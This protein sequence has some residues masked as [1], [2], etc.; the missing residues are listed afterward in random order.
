MAKIK[1]F[2]GLTLIFLLGALA[3]AF[4]TGFYIKEHVEEFLE[5]G[6]PKEKI[7]Q[8]LTRDLDLTSEQQKKIEPILE[9]AHKKLSALRR[10]SLPEM[11]KIREDS[12]ALIKKQLNEDQRKKLQD[13]ENRLDKHRPPHG[14]S[15]STP[16]PTR[17]K[18][19]AKTPAIKTVRGFSFLRDSTGA[20]FLTNRPILLNMECNYLEY[21][22]N[23]A[24]RPATLHGTHS[25]CTICK[26]N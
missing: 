24:K 19:S 16:S 7:M 8:K 11:R 6:P 5:G 9:E 3:G 22:L 18:R 2:A 12:F 4:G 21:F 25:A 15:S 17:R 23:H 10:N 20:C 1:F 14:I 26:I 13:L